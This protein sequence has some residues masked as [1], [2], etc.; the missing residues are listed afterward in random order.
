[1]IAERLNGKF[2]PLSILKKKRSSGKTTPLPQGGGL[3]ESDGYFQPLPKTVG[4]VSDSPP[5]MMH[6]QY[7]HY[8]APPPFTTSDFRSRQ[9]PYADASEYFY[10]PQQQPLPP[11]PEE[12]IAAPTS[13]S[14]WERI[15]SYYD[16]LTFQN[17]LIFLV[18]LTILFVIG[19]YAYRSIRRKI[20]WPRYSLV[21]L[22]TPPTVSTTTITSF[23][24]SE[25]VSASST[26]SPK[27][28]S[29]ALTKAS[30]VL[31]ESFYKTPLLLSR[32]FN[33]ESP[34]DYYGTVKITKKQSAKLTVS[35][36][37]YFEVVIYTYPGWKVVYAETNINEIP[38]D[39]LDEG[40]YSVV[41][42]SVDSIIGELEITKNTNRL[43]PPSRFHRITSSEVAEKRDETLSH[44]VD[45][46]SPKG[47]VRAIH[48]TSS[49]FTVWPGA[50][51]TR[52]ETLYAVVP[53]ETVAIFATFPSYGMIV[54]GVDDHLGSLAHEGNSSAVYRIISKQHESGNYRYVSMTIVYP[55]I[56]PDSP[57]PISPT[58]SLF[59]YTSPMVAQSSS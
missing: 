11:L 45:S 7:H 18:L 50:V 2:D 23:T 30:S 34:G 33:K 37:H 9:A 36:N 1:M 28:S 53:E 35:S 25:D 41:V 19:V 43:K 55:D 56:S 16:Y 21:K 49:P 20:V 17:V 48:I 38:F 15:K 54:D 13:V 14:S 10:S 47:T 46:L 4:G 5:T 22:E 40:T 39:F 59:I 31:S 3:S 44:V 42:F 57:I 24:D 32:P 12:A 51:Y 52:V 58:C 8:D 29:T 26:T 6:Q 27:T